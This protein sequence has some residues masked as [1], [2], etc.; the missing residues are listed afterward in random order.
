M[1]KVIQRK[2]KADLY[3]V[4]SKKRFDIDISTLPEGEY[5]LITRIISHKVKHLDRKRNKKRRLVKFVHFASIDFAREESIEAH[6]NLI[7]IDEFKSTVCL[8]Y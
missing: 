2:I 4:D 5:Q 7:R 6:L 1:A 8:R 3:Q